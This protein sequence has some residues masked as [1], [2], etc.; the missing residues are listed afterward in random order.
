MIEDVKRIKFEELN[1]KKSEI[2]E[3]IAVVE[4]GLNDKQEKLDRLYDEQESSKIALV[5][6]KFT[7]V[8][9]FFT[10]RKEYKKITEKHKRDKE[11]PDLIVKLEQDVSE[12]RDRANKILDERGISKQLESINK[13]LDIIESAKTMPDL[14]ITPIEALQLLEKNGIQPVLTEADKELAVNPRN[15]TSKSS[16]IGVHK[17]DYFPTSNMIKS[18]KD[19]NVEY[20]KEVEIDGTKYQ[21]SYKSDRDTVHMALNDEVSSHI[22]G[23]WDNCKYAALIPLEDIPN[24]KIGRAATQDTF[25]RGSI[26]LSENSWILCPENETEKIKTFNPTVHTIGYK[27]ESVKG[28]AKSFVTQLGYRGEKVGMWSWADEKSKNQ[29]FELLDRE[30][31]KY[32]AHTYTY[33]AEDEKMVQDINRAVSL[34]KLIKDNK[35]A[36]TPEDMQSVMQQLDEQGQGFSSILSDLCKKSS[37]GEEELESGAIVGNNRQVGIFIQKMGEAGFMIPSAYQ[38]F[39]TNMSRIGVSKMNSKNV[40]EFEELLADGRYTEEEIKNCTGLLEIF[41]KEDH[42]EIKDKTSAYSRFIT[43]VI[44]ETVVHSNERE[45][46]NEYSKDE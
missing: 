8:E 22:F 24:E 26:E 7:F 13:Q 3:Q 44:G 42:V 41:N 20:S 34:C 31:L 19:S 14:G 36:K 4:K 15:Y 25:T 1:R 23:S 45:N 40:P 16:L 21:Y 9:K 2:K 27:G 46:I 38:Q 29:F 35:L 39:L 17:T 32:G 6:R 5:E 43:Q 33:F 28:Y 12:E 18:S 10:R 30:G 37:I 11:L